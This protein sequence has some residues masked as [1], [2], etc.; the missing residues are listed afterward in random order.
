M[1]TEKWIRKEKYEFALKAYNN[2]I[3]VK[4]YDDGDDEAP[5]TGTVWN[6]PHNPERVQAVYE[7]G[8]LVE[9]RVFREW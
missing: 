1:I 7:D 2:G 6:I 3:H 4:V 5:L 8:K 9:V